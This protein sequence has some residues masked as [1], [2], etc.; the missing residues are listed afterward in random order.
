MVLDLAGRTAQKTVLKL[1]HH[2]H[3]F[4]HVVFAADAVAPGRQKPENSPAFAPM[5]RGNGHGCEAH[6]LQRGMAVERD[7][8]KHDVPNDCPASARCQA[9]PHL[10]RSRTCRTWL[11]M[12]KT[13]Y[14]NTH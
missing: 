10:A 3:F 5:L 6:D 7:G 2:E 1:Y 13:P 12:A 8:G 14:H 9:A 4:R 11:L